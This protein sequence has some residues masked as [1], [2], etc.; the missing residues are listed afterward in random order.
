MILVYFYIPYKHHVTTVIYD[1]SGM[2]ADEI[3]APA[4]AEAISLYK[5]KIPNL[6][7]KE[8][9]TMVCTAISNGKGSIQAKDFP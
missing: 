8:L 3:A 2:S 7:A 4:V 1:S 9:K 6:T 5:E